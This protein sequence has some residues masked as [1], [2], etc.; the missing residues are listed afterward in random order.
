MHGRTAEMPQQQSQRNTFLWSPIRQRISST[1]SRLSEWEWVCLRMKRCATTLL[2][3]PLQQSQNKSL[4]FEVELWWHRALKVLSIL[5]VYYFSEISH[6][7]W[8]AGCAAAT[9]VLLER[10]SRQSV[11]GI[12]GIIDHEETDVQ[13]CLDAHSNTEAD[14]ENCV[15]VNWTDS[16][17]C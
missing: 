13:S 12:V 16:W 4:H 5:F 8:V 15:F 1:D 10:Q 6:C 14:P 11:R 3:C 7:L 2:W 9:G 17:W